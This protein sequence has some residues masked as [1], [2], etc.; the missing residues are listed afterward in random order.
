MP[1]KISTDIALLVFLSIIVGAIIFPILGNM[2]PTDYES[3]MLQHIADTGNAGSIAGIFHSGGN[4]FVGAYV[5]FAMLLKGL[6]PGLDGIMALRLP[7]AATVMILTLCLF[8]FGGRIDRYS[9]SFLASLLFLSSA[10][11]MRMTFNASVVILPAALFIFALMSLYHW[12]HRLDKRTFWLVATSTA[13]AS[14]IIGATAPISIALMAYVFLIASR[15]R[16]PQSFAIITAALLV[17]CCIAF[18]IIYIITGDTSTAMDIFDI[19]QQLSLLHGEEYSTTHIFVYYIVFAIFPWSIPLIIS[20]PWLIRRPGNLYRRFLGLSLLQRYS[21]IIFLFSLPFLFFFT[22]LSL[23]LIVASMFFNMPL[24]GRY[25]LMQSEHHHRVWKI[26]GYA[27]ACAIAILL[28]SFIIMS[29]GT[30]IH[31]LGTTITLAGG[32]TGPWGIT[33]TVM[34]FFGIYTLWRNARSI[35]QNNRFLYNIIFLYFCSALLCTGYILP[36]LS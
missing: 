20:L 29:A 31:I 4:I 18:L 3:A 10:L 24:I 23:V 6:M 33:L 32:K 15:H 21:V 36:R 9:S 13:I 1:R 5:H 11:I 25:L 27:F 28:V 26:W 14:V 17:A 30:E 22:H 34:A 19:R 12:L 2:P 8:R 16:T 35:G 7:G